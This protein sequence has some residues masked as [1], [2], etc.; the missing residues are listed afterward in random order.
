M[1]VKYFQK[2]KHFQ[3]RFNVTFIQQNKNELFKQ[4]SGTLKHSNLK[5]HVNTVLI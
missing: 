3:N 4:I 1:K 2:V 5:K